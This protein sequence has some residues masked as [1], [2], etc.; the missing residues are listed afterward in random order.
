ML[1][2]QITVAICAHRPRFEIFVQALDALRKQ[3][4][5]SDQW[6]LLVV[7]DAQTHATARRAGLSWHPRVKLL[8]EEPKGIA[9]ARVRA[10]K[11]FLQGGS[12]LLVFVD[13]DNLLAPD[14]LEVG[15]DLAKREPNLGCWGGQL[16]G[17]FE[18]DPPEWIDEFLKY[19]AVFPFE[20]E[21]RSHSYA[22]SYDAIPPTAGMFLRRPVAEHHLRL[23]ESA[24]ARLALGGTRAAPICGEDMDLGFGAFDLGYEIGRFPQLKLTH[25]I[26][27]DRLTENYIARLLTSIRAGTI[28]L[29]AIRG[30]DRP[31]RSP[32][33]LWWDRVRALRL[34]PRHRK[35]MLAETEGEFL[36]RRILGDLKFPGF[37]PANT[38]RSMDPVEAAG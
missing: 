19:I 33:S 8:E 16:I 10:L 30:I 18:V 20:E 24:P 26:S 2:S 38:G 13:D 31:T 25:L 4:L 14:F 22:G 11:E 36:A 29:E 1:P 5:S 9:R 37:L 7:G 23:V 6:E 21:I 12:D 17:S 3:T 15:L 32:L 27:S 28:I 35:F 34:P